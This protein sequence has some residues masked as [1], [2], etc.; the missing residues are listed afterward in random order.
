M[1]RNQREKEQG[2]A[3]SYSTISE[4]WEIW[5]ENP[6]KY[7]VGRESVEEM[8]LCLTGR[9]M[10]AVCLCYFQQKTQKEAAREFG[11]SRPA[12]ATILLQ[13]VKRLQ[14]N[15]CSEVRKKRWWR[16]YEG[17]SQRNGKNK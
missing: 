6:L 8:H 14:K 15:I 13:L 7:L 16:L 5:G 2:K 10:R 3:I 9:Q 11:V 1:E 12:I 4:E 17:K